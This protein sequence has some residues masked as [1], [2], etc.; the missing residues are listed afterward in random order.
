M[1]Y[2]SGIESV[3]VKCLEGNSGYK[4]LIIEGLYHFTALRGWEGIYFVCPV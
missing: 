2:Q 4:Q 1:S 3:L